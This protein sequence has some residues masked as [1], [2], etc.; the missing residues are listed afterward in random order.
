MRHTSREA[1]ESMIPHL[2][3]VREKVY[4]AICADAPK[5]FEEV[6]TMLEMKHQTVSSSI[7][8]LVKE[9][10]LEDSGERG[11]TVSGRKAIRWKPTSKEL[12]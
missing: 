3:T 5:T 6:E 10:F 2:S 4:S 12:R 1:Y 7:H 8:H 9:G 11:L